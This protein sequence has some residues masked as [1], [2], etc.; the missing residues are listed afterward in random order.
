MMNQ[1]IVFT[2][3]GVAELL[4][5]P[6]PTVGDGD[7]LVKIV[8]TSISAGTERA[9]MALIGHASDEMSKL[10]THQELRDLK[11]VTDSM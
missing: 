11:E 2:A 9:K 6:M 5:A 1:K 7:V 4:D 8:R 10:Y 3:R